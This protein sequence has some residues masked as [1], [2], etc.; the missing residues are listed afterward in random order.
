MNVENV[1]IE[2]PQLLLYR[3]SSQFNKTNTSSSQSD[4]SN[5]VA[6]SS[7]SPKHFDVITPK[8]NANGAT[9]KVDRQENI[10]EKSMG[11]NIQ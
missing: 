4:W 5:P 3:T 6:Q 1:L 7:K 9:T 11:T 2:P 8:A 10:A